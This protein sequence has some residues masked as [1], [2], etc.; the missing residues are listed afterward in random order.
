MAAEEELVRA[1]SGPTLEEL[2]A[3]AGA[4]DLFLF[5]RVEANRFAHI[6]GAGRGVGW[7][8]IVEVS[9]AQEPMLAAAV[10]EQ[11]VLQRRE[12]DA[13]HVFGPYYARSAAIVPLDHDLIAVFGSPQRDAV[14]LDPEELRALGR[15]AS[16]SVEDVTAAKRLADELE[17][18][19]AVRDLLCLKA[20]TFEETLHAFADHARNALSCEIG[21][22]SVTDQQLLA[23]SDPRELIG[24]D[25]ENLTAAMKLLRE[26]REY[27]LCIQDAHANDLPSPFSSAEGAVSYYLL[28]LPHPAPGLLLLIHTREAPRGF[29][30][31]C[32][33]LGQRLV[34]AAGALFATALAHDAMRQDLRH[35]A[36]QARTD[37]LTGLAN[38]LAWDEAIAAYEQG[39]TASI[40]QLDCRGLKQANETK[41]H[42]VGDQLLRTI[43]GAIR[44]C[45]RESDT[46]ARIGGDEFA[47]LL[48]DTDEEAAAA[49]V[50]RINSAISARPAIET[51]TVAAAIGVATTTT[52]DLCAAQ[53]E[54][55]MAMRAAKRVS[56]HT[57]AAT[58]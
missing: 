45:L 27:P 2:A 21:V 50:S 6:G 33:A 46:Y 56:E 7:A 10:A 49:V 52:G 26:R 17:V 23:V 36:A 8:G 44:D 51:V 41:G 22:V 31:L 29:T 43:A 18:V 47:I 3:A 1:A 37:A 39:P 30:Q 20:D 16:E 25:H 55:D 38:R 35:A 14:A 12:H 40:I 13:W 48:P 54:A 11:D 4:D 5:R 9:L 32:Q 24:E 28:K 58:R 57:A 19:N 42:H 15:Y 53:Q 34:D